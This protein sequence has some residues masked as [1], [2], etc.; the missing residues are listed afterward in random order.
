MKQAQ[1]GWKNMSAPHIITRPVPVHPHM[2]LEVIP[3][4]CA[5]SLVQLRVSVVKDGAPISVRRTPRRDSRKRPSE[6]GL[7]TNYMSMI[8]GYVARYD[9]LTNT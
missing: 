1:T 4:T 5:A 9:P 6:Y 3:E 7:P 2:S 8:D